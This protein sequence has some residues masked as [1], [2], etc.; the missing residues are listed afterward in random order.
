MR[1]LTWNV[2]SLKAFLKRKGQLLPAALEALGA[3]ELRDPVGKRTSKNADRS[4]LQTSSASRR[5]S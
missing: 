3:G 1:L 2:N 4:C 5:P